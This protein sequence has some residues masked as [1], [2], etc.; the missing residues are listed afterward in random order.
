MLNNNTGWIRNKMQDGDCN[1][2]VTLR[3]SMAVSNFETE[4]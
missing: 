2:M 4:R 1:E 3:Q